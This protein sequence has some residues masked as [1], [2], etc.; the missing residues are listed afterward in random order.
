MT[1]APGRP[2][3]LIIVENLPCPFDRRVW[4]EALAL[5]ANGYDVTIICPKG[6]G[7]E[8]SHEV[9][10]GI[11]IYRHALPVEADSATGY[12][13]EYTVSLALEFWLALRVAFTRGFDILH[14]C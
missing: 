3:V 10:D 5:T 8:K 6:R 2:G 7:F 13:I 12:A 11:H 14:A 1:A 4:Q 9:L